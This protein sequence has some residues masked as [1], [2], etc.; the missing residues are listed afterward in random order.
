MI[1]PPK[2]LHFYSEIS[3]KI[4]EKSMSFLPSFYQKIKAFFLQN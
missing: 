1:Q 2:T 3:R 4:A